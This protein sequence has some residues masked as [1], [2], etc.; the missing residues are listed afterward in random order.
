MKCPLVLYGKKII[1]KLKIE[2]FIKISFFRFVTSF[3]VDDNSNV[4]K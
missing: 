4:S 2:I 3:Q 1:K